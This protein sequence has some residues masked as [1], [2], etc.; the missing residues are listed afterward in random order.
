MGVTET[1][2]RCIIDNGSLTRSYSIVLF[3]EELE[4]DLGTPHIVT[5]NQGALA[6]ATNPTHH[7]R[8]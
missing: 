8:S 2:H 6:I 3:L 1:A 5:S 4:L 7:N